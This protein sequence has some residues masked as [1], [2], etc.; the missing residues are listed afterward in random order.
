MVLNKKAQAVTMGSLQGIVWLLVVIGIMLAVGLVVLSELRDTASVTGDAETALNETI[1][2][3]GEIPG[4]LSIIVVV[5]IAA[6]ILG[7]VQ[8]FRRA[9]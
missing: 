9:G 4:W 5:V 1:D 7:L 6:V 8:F 3:I 2:A